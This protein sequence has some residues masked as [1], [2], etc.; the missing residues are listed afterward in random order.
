MLP[1]CAQ[2][3][4]GFPHKKPVGGFPGTSTTQIVPG[5]HCSQ[6]VTRAHPVVQSVQTVPLPSA[7]YPHSQ[8]LGQLGVHIGSPPERTPSTHSC[9]SA[10]RLE[11]LPQWF[12]FLLRLTHL[13][14]QRVLPSG[15]PHTL[16]SPRLTQFFEQHWWSLLHSLPKRLQP[17]A[18]ATPGKEAAQLLEVHHQPNSLAPREGACCKSLGQLVEGSVGSALAHLCACSPEGGTRKGPAALRNLA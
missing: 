18:Q 17:S 12:S 1:F 5:L 13:S 7:R 16:S 4:H 3:W 6:L 15:Q 14:L 8:P 11:Q 10:Q 2:D 9:P